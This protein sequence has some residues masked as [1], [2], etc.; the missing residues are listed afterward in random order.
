MFIYTKVKILS[1]T[2]GNSAI[3]ATPS[4]VKSKRWVKH[5]KISEIKMDRKWEK[6][7]KKDE[8][9]GTFDV[10]LKT[11]KGNN[12]WFKVFYTT[13]IRLLVNLFSSI[14]GA[15]NTSEL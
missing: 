15:A 2:R 8:L 9:G 13:Q 14:S 7:G 6:K 4:R 10:F 11:C 5:Q 3:L 12:E 1:L